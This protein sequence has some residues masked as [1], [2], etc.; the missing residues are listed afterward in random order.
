MMNMNATN[1][2]ASN[3]TAN[4]ATASRRALLTVPAPGPGPGPGV[5]SRRLDDMSMPTPFP[6][7][8]YNFKY[9][10]C[11]ELYGD[12]GD[13]SYSEFTAFPTA[14]PTK[15][16]TAEPTA[17]SMPSISPSSEPTLEPTYSQAPSAAPTAAPVAGITMMAYTDSASVSEDGTSAWC[18]YVLGSQPPGVYTHPSST[19]HM[20]PLA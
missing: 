13:Q 12:L 7:S 11:L 14:T 17:T 15:D 5:H 19:S 6:S 8:E 9:A 16:E 4:N 2:T 20:P 3:A 1:A 18:V 10:Q